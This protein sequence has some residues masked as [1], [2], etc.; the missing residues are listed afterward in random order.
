M[1]KKLISG[2][3]KFF[4]GSPERVD[5]LFDKGVELVD[6]AFF[7]KQEKSKAHAKSFD[8]YIEWIKASSPQNATRREIALLIT[9]AW[10]I[11]LF[12]GVIAEIGGLHVQSAFVFKV[13]KEIVMYPFLT[14]I[15]FYFGKQLAG[16]VGNVINNTVKK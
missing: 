10:I 7:T 14:V 6:N 11:L 1:F 2:F 13:L 4:A 15:I 12:A 5:T 9:K 16:V 3:G 8:Q